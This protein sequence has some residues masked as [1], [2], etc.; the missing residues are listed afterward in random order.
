M[1]LNNVLDAGEHCLLPT[2]EI[3]IALHEALGSD[4]LP[5]S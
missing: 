2:V 3:M 1:G 5:R 4:Y